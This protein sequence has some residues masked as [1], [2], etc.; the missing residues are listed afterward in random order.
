MKKTGLLLFLFLSIQFLVR[1]QTT[2][3]Q[4]KKLQVIVFGAHPDDCDITTGGLAALYVSMGHAVKF[5]S[6]TNGDKGHQTIG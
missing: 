3:G 6:L 2:S 1:S 5:V 4:N